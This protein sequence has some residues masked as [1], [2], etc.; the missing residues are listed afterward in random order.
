VHAA[1]DA[2]PGNNQGRRIM[3][4]AIRTGF[5]IVLIKP[6][7]YDD[8]GYVIQWFRSYIPSNSLAT[9]YG[10]VLDCASREVLGRHELISVDAHDE[11]NT[12]IRPARI[13]RQITDQGGGMVWLVGVQTNQ[14]PRAMDLARSFRALGVQVVIG[15]FH[16]SGVLSMLP[17]ITP[18]LQQAIKLGISLF[19]GEAEGAIDE[20]IQDGASGRLKPVYRHLGGLPKL[21]GRPVPFLPLE[22]VKRTAGHMTTFDAGRGCPFQ[23]SFCTIINVQGRASRYRTAEDVE[24]IIRTNS[25]C[26]I[27]KFFIT[28]DNFVRNRNWEPILDCLIRMREH[29]GFRIELSVQIDTRCHQVPRFLDKAARAGVDRVFL[30]LETLHA[31]SLLG[32]KKRQNRVDEYRN[33]LL[34]W[35]KRKVV[36]WAGYIIGFDRDTYA[37]VMQDVRTIQRELPVDFLEFFVLTPLPGSEDHKKLALSGTPMDTDLNRY[38]TWHVVIDHPKMSRQEWERAYW[39]AWRTYYSVNHMTRLLRRAAVTG[40]PLAKLLNMLLSFWTLSQ[41]ERL[42]PLEGGFF[43]RKVRKD[44]RPGKLEAPRARFLWTLAIER[45]AACARIGVMAGRLLC[46]ALYIWCDPT[47]KD[48]QDE[49]LA[50]R[51]REGIPDVTTSPR[52]R[53]P[54]VPSTGA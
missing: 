53:A 19:A 12:R 38:D 34:E 44:R 14:F 46:R 16:V 2:A 27:T 25:S 8:E 37:T 4:A 40:I 33:M 23:C 7:H 5:H 24:A 31:E 50:G 29:E 43:R 52:L 54:T 42:H 21:A 30:G 15:G 22:R 6:S 51:Q 49:A 28:D 45:S 3:V 32:S 17:A 20:L 36:I 10:L 26:G 35:K 11:T 1:A 9:L 47:A 48:Y 41:V 39:E 18:E 13:A